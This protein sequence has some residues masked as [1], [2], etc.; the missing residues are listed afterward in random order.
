MF[1]HCEDPKAGLLLI[2]LVKVAQFISISYS[3]QFLD[4][5]TSVFNWDVI[6]KLNI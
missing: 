4:L 2:V 1:D 6:L 3:F 5:N